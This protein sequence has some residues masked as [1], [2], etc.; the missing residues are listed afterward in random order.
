MLLKGLLAGAFLL[1]ILLVWVMVQ[2]LYRRFA[3]ENPECGPFREDGGNSTC[4]CCASKKFCPS[5]R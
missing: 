1:V 5:A 3:Q 4:S 2:H